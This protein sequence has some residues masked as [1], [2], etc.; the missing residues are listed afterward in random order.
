MDGYHNNRFVR[1]YQSM[2]DFMNSDNFTSH[3]L[4][5]PWSGTGQVVYNGSIYF[6][7][8][9]SHTIIKFDFKKHPPSVS[10]ANWTTLAST[11][12]TTTH[13]VAILT[14]T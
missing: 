14:L 12:A 9:Q 4:P 8:F 1:E 7:K 10:P 3:R 13:G 6:N 5:H 11:T 2:V